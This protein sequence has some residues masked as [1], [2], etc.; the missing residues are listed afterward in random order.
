ME[1]DKSFQFNDSIQDSIHSPSSKPSS[2][3]AKPSSPINFQ[4]AMGHINQQVSSTP[5]LNKEG[6]ALS[7]HQSITTSSNKTSIVKK[8][9]LN[10]II[11]D[12]PEQVYN[13]IT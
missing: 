4:S 10:E 11:D 9:R 6:F 7:P 1:R 2:S 13:F 8:K 5:A 3:F 12:S